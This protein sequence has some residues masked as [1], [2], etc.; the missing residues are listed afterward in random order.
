VGAGLDQPARILRCPSAQPQMSDA[1]AIGV[2]DRSGQSPEVAYLE[3]PVPA[4]AELLE[5]ARPLNPT[6]VF[7][8]A[9]PCQTS[10]CSHWDGSECKLVTRIVQMIPA[11][12]LSLP[13]C[14]VRVVC[15]W[16]VQ[17]G[18]A[19]CQRCPRV[20]TQNEDP[21]DAMREAAMPK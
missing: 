5:M 11:E 10:A 12:S 17:A 2:V 14:H 15:R 19:A 8:F 21:S 13:R 6:E 9:A 18:R 16:F 1:V 7:R 20:V 4:T 3:R